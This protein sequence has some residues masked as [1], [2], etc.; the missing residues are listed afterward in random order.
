M[1]PEDLKRIAVEILAVSCASL[2]DEKEFFDIKKYLIVP[3]EC[4]VETFVETVSH[5]KLDISYEL[6]QVTHWVTKAIEGINNFYSK[7]ENPGFT[8]S[9]LWEMDSKAAIRELHRVSGLGI[10]FWDDYSYEEHGFSTIP[11][12]PYIESPYFLALDVLDKLLL[13]ISQ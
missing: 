12:V 6:D 2:T 10:S 7:S 8:F 11:E 9:D 5:F 4:I 13:T 3:Q 1:N